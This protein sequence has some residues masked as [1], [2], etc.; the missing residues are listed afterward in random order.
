[1]INSARIA[2]FS[3]F[4]CAGLA[5]RPLPLAPLQVILNGLL[6]MILRQRPSLFAPLRKGE[7]LM[8]LID[9]IDFPCVFLFEPTAEP[10]ILQVQRNGYG[11]HPSATVA[12]PLDVLLALLTG[13]IDGDAMFFSRA[14]TIS[15]DTQAVVA[16][17]N[18][19][20][21]A[22][23][24]LVR[25]LAS[26][27]GPLASAVQ[28]ILARGGDLLQEVD[29]DLRLLA[30]ALLAPLQRH[31]DAELYP[32]QGVNDRLARLER[33]R[34]GEEGVHRMAHVTPHEAGVREMVSVPALE[35]I[36]KQLS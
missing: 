2:P 27:F 31:L 16:L 15:G 25:M 20:D 3:L 36:E 5:L 4:L 1:M 32:L 14:L 34:Y 19:L 8:F 11:V 24:D 12:A 13:K 21:G 28:G 33:R 26:R 18:A 22:D 17:N 29:A 30:T 35:N 10:P 6:R 7:Q 23:I 9:P